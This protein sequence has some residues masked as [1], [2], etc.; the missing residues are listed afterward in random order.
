MLQKRGVLNW[1]KAHLDYIDK[2][3]EAQK[4]KDGL[5]VGGF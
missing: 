1:G 2:E 3:T 5:K 4:G